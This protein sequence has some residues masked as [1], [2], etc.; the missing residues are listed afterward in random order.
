MEYRKLGKSGLKVSELSFGSWVT[1]NTQVNTKLAEDM[2]KVCFDSGINFFDNAEG[3]DRGKSEEVMGQALKS[4]NEPRDSYCVSSKVFFSS[5][6]NPKPT[7]LGLSKKHVTEACHQAMKR[8]Q[9][10]YLDLYF[11]HRADPDT[12]IGETVWA[13]HN[14][15]TQGKVL[16]WGTSEWTA[17]E[18]TE[19]YEFAEKN[20]LTP[21]TMEQPQYN[22]LDRKRFEVEY[23]PI[24]RRYQ[25]GTTIWSPLA[26]G[27][28]TGK[29]LDGI[30]EGSRATLKGYE[31]LKKHMIDSERGQARMD[32]VRN[33]KPIAD[34]LGVSLSKMSIAWCLLNPNVS[35]VIL[36]AS[37]VD[38]LKENLEALEVVPLLTEDVQRKLAGI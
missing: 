27:A 33:L 17:E 35:T 22:L 7:Q 5:S 12:P 24:F 13:M 9:V 34:E 36:G 3:Y 29:Y 18:I 30:P 14:L 37:R 26:S 25:M 19:A 2:F 21:P 32:K 31:W 15:I 23:D 8:L 1:F 38:Q 10:D 28:L 4:I 16:Y 11:C 6:P 20:H